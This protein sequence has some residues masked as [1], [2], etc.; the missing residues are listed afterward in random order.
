MGHEQGKGLGRTGQGIVKPI[1]ESTQQSKL[2]LGYK[3]EKTTAFDKSL[4]REWN[5]D[6]DEVKSFSIYL[7]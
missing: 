1:D 3:S 6:T 5:F 2:G 7:L 4:F